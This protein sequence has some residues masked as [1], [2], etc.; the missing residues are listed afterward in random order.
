M[1]SVAQIYNGKTIAYYRS[2]GV[3][4]FF[5]CTDRSNINK[6]IRGVRESAG[7][8][9]WDRTNTSTRG[10]GKV[11]AS[12]PSGEVVAVFE[13][14]E[15]VEAASLFLRPARIKAVI[16]GTKKTA[17]TYVWSYGK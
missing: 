16:N 4:A 15:A 3:A 17:Y 12:T 1:N 8:F 7:A 2:A 13:N 9:S 14:M 11:I 6:V 10:K 5:T